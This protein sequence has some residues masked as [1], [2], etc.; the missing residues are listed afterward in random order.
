MFSIVVRAQMNWVVTLLASLILWGFVIVG[1]VAPSELQKV[2]SATASISGGGGVLPEPP[3]TS[4]HMDHPTLRAR[5][6]QLNSWGL[7]TWCQCAHRNRALDGDRRH[8]GGR[9][10]RRG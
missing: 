5:S 4:R 9:V 1:V 3:A 8:F 2:P 6:I 10:R 7:P